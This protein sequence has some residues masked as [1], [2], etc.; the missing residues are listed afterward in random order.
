MRTNTDKAIGYWLGLAVGVTAVLFVLA[1]DRAR[2]AE[3][4][5]DAKIK[6]LQ[7]ELDKAKKEAEELRLQL[8]LQQDRS[9]LQ[10]LLLKLQLKQEEFDRKQAQRQ[11]EIE[12]FRK[13]IVEDKLK[14]DQMLADRAG[15]TLEEWR[16]ASPDRK[17]TIPL[18]LAPLPKDLL[19]DR[20]GK[21]P[22]PPPLIAGLRGQVTD[23]ADDLVVLSV[24]IDAGLEV[25]AVLDIYRTEG[26]PR[27]LGTVKITNRLNL[28]PKQS[29]ATFTP[30]RKVALDKLRPEELPKKGDEVRPLK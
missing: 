20:L 5:K 28:M 30:A 18:P 15:M 6:Q 10:L 23:A 19:L 24:G 21:V 2:A 25:G 9:E 12:K 14:L 8:R 22:K 29:I 11:Q 16:K 17:N 13:E 27:Y 3:D 7:A 26:G 4:P 1:A